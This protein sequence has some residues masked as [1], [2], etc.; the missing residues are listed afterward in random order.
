MAKAKKQGRAGKKA[1][2]HK[3]AKQQDS[4]G[5]AGEGP[6]PS[7]RLQHKVTKKVD[8]LAKVAS[9]ATAASAGVRKKQPAAKKKKKF[10]KALADFSSIEEALRS[11]GSGSPQQSPPS[12]GK[13]GVGGAGSGRKRMKLTKTESS[14]LKTVLE[15]PQYRA[16]P[17]SAIMNHLE[18]TLPPRP[19]P[20]AAAR[21]PWAQRRPKKPDRKEPPREAME[22]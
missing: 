17:L 3:Q 4:A 15:H 10:S 6:R 20:K 22:S 12:R 9:S 18:A 19:D 11:V 8:F 13:K 7:Q 2:L 1:S 5:A 14:R 16:G 21:P